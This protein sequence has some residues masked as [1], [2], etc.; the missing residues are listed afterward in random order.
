MAALPGSPGVNDGRCS[1][2]HSCEEPAPFGWMTLTHKINK[3]QWLA[4]RKR[5]ENVVQMW[6]GAV[7]EAPREAEFDLSHRPD[8][9]VSWS[10]RRDSNPRPSP[11]QIRRGPTPLPAPLQIDAGRSEYLTDRSEP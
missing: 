6:C 8:Q 2:A 3:G 4:S 1:A 7:P 10:G 9:D 5:P 11:W